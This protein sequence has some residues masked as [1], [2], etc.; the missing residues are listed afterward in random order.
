MARR[1]R[2]RAGFQ[3]TDRIAEVIRAVVATELERLDDDRL[4]LVT[5]T[6]VEVDA[7]LSSAQVY[8]S[9]IYAEEQG[10]L[11]EVRDALE[12]LRWPIQRILNAEI[13]ARR[14]PQI[15]FAPDEVL[16]RALHL[17]D[18]MAGRADPAIEED[19]ERGR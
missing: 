5:V 17:E 1:P 9:A 12:D 13:R 2:G 7:D 3:R 16:R 19:E 10:R 14:T 4:E 6:A 15:V 8:Y 11:D 18:L